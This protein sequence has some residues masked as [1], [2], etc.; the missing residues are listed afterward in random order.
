MLYLWVLQL[1][2]TYVNKDETWHIRPR[3]VVHGCHGLWC[4]VVWWDD[5]TSTEET[6]V[7]QR[8]D[9]DKAMDYVIDGLDEALAYLEKQYP[10]LSRQNLIKLVLEI[11]TGMWY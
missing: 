9:Y 1:G 8:Q 6:S 11:A 5:M 2:E 7:I 3:C 4:V 10:Q